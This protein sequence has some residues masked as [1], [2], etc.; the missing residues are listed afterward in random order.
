MGLRHGAGHEPAHVRPSGP[1]S[2]TS[3][4][5]WPATS[6]AFA[7][8]GGVPRRLVPDNLKTGVVR[9]DLYDPKLNLAYGELADHYGSSSTRPG[10]QTQGQASGGAPDALRP[11]QLLGR[12]RI[13]PPTDMQA[14]ALPGAATWPVSGPPTARRR[15]AALGLS[16]GRGPALITLPQHRRSSWRRGRDR[17]SDP[18]ATSRSARPCTR[19]PGASSARQVD[20]RAGERTVEV[21]TEGRGDQDLGPDRTGRQTDWADYPPHKVAFFMRTPVWCRRRAGRARPSVAEVVAGLLE[22]GALHRLRAAQGVLGLA[23]STAPTASTWRAAGPSTSVTPAIAPIKGILPAGTEDEG[24]TVPAHRGPRPIS[25]APTLSSPSGRRRGQ[26]D[27]DGPTSSRPH[28]AASRLSGMLET[29]EARLAQAG[30][31]EL[32]HVEFLQALCEDELSRR[33]TPPAS[34]AGARG[35]LRAGLRHR[36]LR[37][38]LQ[39]QDPRRPHP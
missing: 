37:L 11:R 7:F 26:R 34:P 39:P 22:D 17:K 35:P 1:S 21:F 27:D 25:T 20:A 9:P 30:A 33:Q 19:C 4:P 8:F 2:W 29:L 38:Q 12:G 14:G 15:L 24:T 36:G 10:Q 18:T 28:C 23:E 32:G 16:G 5:G 13:L 6:Q 3:A 31:G